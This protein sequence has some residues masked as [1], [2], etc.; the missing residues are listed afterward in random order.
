MG[1]SILLRFFSFLKD[2]TRDTK[3]NC[4]WCALY[5]INDQRKQVRADRSELV[6]NK[7]VEFI[8]KKILRCGGDVF[9]RSKHEHVRPYF[10]MRTRLF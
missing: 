10:K 8:L 9:V 1:Q 2:P 3:V 4:H 5:N 7:K 6:N